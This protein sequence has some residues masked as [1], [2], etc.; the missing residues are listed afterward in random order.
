[1]DGTK[2]PVIFP[3]MDGTKHPVFFSSMDGTKHPLFSHPWM[4]LNIQC[5]QN[6]KFWF[7]FQF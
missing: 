1:M 7:W 6:D 3:S 5:F 2:H 4:E